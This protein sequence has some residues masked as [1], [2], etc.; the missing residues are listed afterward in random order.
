MKVIKK[1]CLDLL[2]WDGENNE[3]FEIE[4]DFIDAAYNFAKSNWPVN[5]KKNFQP[6]VDDLIENFTGAFVKKWDLESAFWMIKTQVVEL[7]KFLHDLG[8]RQ[9]IIFEMCRFKV[10]KM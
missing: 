5:V 6:R 8:F 3:N 10:N 2:I 1:C 7:Q 9:P 4:N